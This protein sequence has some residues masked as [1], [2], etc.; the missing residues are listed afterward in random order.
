MVLCISIANTCS[1]HDQ[2]GLHHRGS[3]HHLRPASVKLLDVTQH[4]PRYYYPQQQLFTFTWDVQIAPA[5]IQP[6]PQPLLP[7]QAQTRQP[8]TYAGLTS[9]FHRSATNAGQVG[10]SLFLLARIPTPCLSYSIPK[11]GEEG[12]GRAKDSVRMWQLVP[13]QAALLQR[14]G[15]LH[16]THYKVGMQL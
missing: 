10:E 7:R 14:L 8:C 2:A 5:S 16:I 15:W 9:H 1:R 4:V 13:V 12:Y 11:L 6:Q 3:S